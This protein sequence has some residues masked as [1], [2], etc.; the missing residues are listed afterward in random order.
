M[1]RLRF[2]LTL[3]AVGG[4]A[5]V[6]PLLITGAYYQNLCILTLLYAVVASNWDLTIG[7]TGLF[8][9]AH[10][11]F[12]GLGA[13]TSGILTVKYGIS[14][15]LGI[16]AA[17]ALNVVVGAA[18][19]FPATRLRGIYVALTTFAFTELASALIVSRTSLTG[20]SAGL[21]LIPSISFAGYDFGVHN[22]G[23]FYLGEILLIVS[24]FLLRALLKSDF[25]LSFV[26]I[27][28][29]EDYA[30]SRGVPVARQ[31]LVALVV[32][33]VFTS[34]AG[35]IYAH[36]LGVA[37]P[38]IF[39]FGFVTLFLSMVILGGSG[40]LYGPIV[41][42][43]ALTF[44]TEWRELAGY[45]DLRFMIVS[46]VIVAVLLFARSGLWGALEAIWR[47][48]R[49]RHRM[50]DAAAEAVAEQN[51][52]PTEAGPAATVTEPQAR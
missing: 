13:Y 38:D 27:R 9:F 18:M 8:N 49:G 51:Q 47:L 23:Y 37:S 16:A 52:V 42:A 35:A 21:V 43:V 2:L 7:Y 44:F 28:E 26:A 11:A 29:F 4:V 48:A 22:N 46:G 36:Y 6:L 33:A 3:A 39:G 20:G 34:A 5:V 24:T 10:I 14:P 50:S 32:S 1:K 41:A 31:R 45:G 40:T 19:A 15:W 25:G 30:A 12:F 17:I